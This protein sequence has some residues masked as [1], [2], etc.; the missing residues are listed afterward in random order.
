MGRGDEAAQDCESG[1]A[2]NDPAGRARGRCNNRS[3]QRDH[4]AP[5]LGYLL[6]ISMIR[7]SSNARANRTMMISPNGP[8]RPWIRSI[9][10][11][12]ARND[13]QARMI[14][15]AV[16]CRRLAGKLH[17]I[18]IFSR[19]LS[20]AALLHCPGFRLNVCTA[21]ASAAS[22]LGA[23]TSPSTLACLRISDARQERGGDALGNRLSGA[24]TQR[25]GGISH[26]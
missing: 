4:G 11:A 2:G 6:R 15:P 24:R 10:S 21:G 22:R 5:F 9:A 1:P 26:S 3:A 14:T 20:S 13:A 18:G 23:S 12:P 16:I 25:H 17:L 19:A 8:P 7:P